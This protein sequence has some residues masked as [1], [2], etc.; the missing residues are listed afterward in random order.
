MNPPL[1]DRKCAIEFETKRSAVDGETE[2]RTP[3]RH[4]PSLAPDKAR[5][6]NK[7][8]PESHLHSAL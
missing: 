1:F 3:S 2:V 7:E 5:G 4:L 8:C 6:R